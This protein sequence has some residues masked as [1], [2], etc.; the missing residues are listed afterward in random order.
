MTKRD[1][2][3]IEIIEAIEFS[4][5]TIS[6]ADFKDILGKAKQ[7]LRTA[8][9]KIGLLKSKSGINWAEVYRTTPDAM[10]NFV[11][12][13]QEKDRNTAYDILAKG[14]P[15]VKN[16]A[17]KN[18]SE[19]TK[20]ILAYKKDK[21]P[22]LKANYIKAKN[23]ILKLLSGLWAEA[24]AALTNLSQTTA[25]RPKESTDISLIARHI[26]EDLGFNNG[27]VLEE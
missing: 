25:S 23:Q 6:E 13:I 22:E 8:G 26:T 4:R 18:V 1:K 17:L 7:G 10:K 19:P 11:L 12:A 14:H 5:S 27:L 2:E 20:V 21:N 3:L 9:E 24:D 15:E 16:W